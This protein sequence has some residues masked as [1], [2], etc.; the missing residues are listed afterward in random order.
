MNIRLK[1]LKHSGNCA[2][3]ICI[4]LVS[5]LFF[6]SESQAD[7]YDDAVINARNTPKVE[8]EVK[9]PDML[10]Y[11]ET[12]EYIQ[13]SVEYPFIEISHCNFQYKDN[14]GNLLTISYFN[15]GDL[16]AI[17]DKRNQLECKRMSKCFKQDYW[18]NTKGSLYKTSNSFIFME[19]PE[20]T[21]LK[22]SQLAESIN[23]LV[24]L[25]GGS[26]EH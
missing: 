11:E 8:S 19:M 15:A 13:K 20:Y 16:L 22:A 25:C 21:E 26:K 9:E 12:V 6:L 14:S 7:Q 23:H 5:T 1:I 10:S 4:L 3:Q 24:M 17:L 18:G 2:Y